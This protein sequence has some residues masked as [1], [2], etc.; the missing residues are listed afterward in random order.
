VAAIIY[1]FPARKLKIVGITG[2]KGKTTT[3]VFTGR[4]ANQCGIKTGYISTACIYLGDDQGEFLN[5]YKMTAIDGFMMQKHLRQMVK[6]GCQWVILEMSSQGLE[7]NRHVGLF[8]FDVAVFLNITPEHIE[9]HG[10]FANYK[11]AKG[12]LFANL[13]QD[14]L[15]IFNGSDPQ[16][17]FMESLIRK[18]HQSQFIYPGQDFR[19]ETLPGEMTKKIWLKGKYYSTNLLADF[20]I[21]N[22]AFAEQIVAKI[23]GQNTD[24]IAQ[25]FTKIYTVPGRMDWVVNNNRLMFPQPADP[26]IQISQKGDLSILVDYAHEPESLKLLLNTLV[27][28][29]NQ[30]YF[31]LIIHVLSC[32]GAGRDDWKKPIM[33]DISYQLADYNILTTD[34]Y[35]AKDNPQQIV[36]MLA[37][38]YPNQTENSKYFK[39]IN[40]AKAFQQA[41]SLGFQLSLQSN[42]AS[43]ILICSTG[44][45]SEQGLTQPEGKMAWDERSK[46]LEFYKNAIESLS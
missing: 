46:W 42:P 40:R 20:D 8:G 1:G 16:A 38:N 14:G 11:K 21:F 29:K 7:Q 12:I 34:N 43:K 24:Q 27:S 36:D 41:I 4:L 44:V 5:P 37:Q 9:A 19:A 22:L 31:D 3:T 17:T 45:G 10:S 32:D 39:I 18:P 23:T 30:G 33:G 35:D 2:T 28:W 6:N 26:A 13:K 25:H 15:G